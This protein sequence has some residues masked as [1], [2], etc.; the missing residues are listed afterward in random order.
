[1]HIAKPQSVIRLHYSL[2]Q[3]ASCPHIKR[4]DYTDPCASCPAGHFGPYII[5]DALNPIPPA[6]PHKP[7][8]HSVKKGPG[9]ILSTMLSHLGLHP[10][11]TC[12]CTSHK[13]MMDQNGPTWCRENINLIASWLRQEAQSLHRPHHAPFIRALAKT[14]FFTPLARLL[15]HLAIR[16]AR[17]LH[18]P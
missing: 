11:P 8:F 6:K 16:Q 15:I 7:Q 14:P 10:T 18:T 3:R 1:M 9:T 4:L 5:C 2:C 13:K 12:H 17:P